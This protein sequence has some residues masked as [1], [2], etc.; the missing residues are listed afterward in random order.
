[1]QEPSRENLR[2]REDGVGGVY[3]EG[4]S[5]HVVRNTGG[6]MSLLHEGKRLRTTGTTKMNKARILAITIV[7]ARFLCWGSLLIF[8]GFTGGMGVVY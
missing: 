5:E 3:I 4:L 1:M 7:V 2:V 6:I 8:L